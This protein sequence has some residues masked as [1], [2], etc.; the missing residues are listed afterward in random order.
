MFTVFI[1]VKS[2]LNCKKLNKVFYE[3]FYV[4]FRLDLRG[5]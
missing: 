1:D 5:E 3:N 2:F 4:K